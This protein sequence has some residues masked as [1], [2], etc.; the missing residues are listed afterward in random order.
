MRRYLAVL[1]GFMTLLA[2]GCRR[3]AGVPGDESVPPPVGD[4]RV[5]VRYADLNH[6]GISEKIRIDPS[7]TENVTDQTVGVFGADDQREP[8]LLWSET[9][10]TSPDGRGGIYL[11]VLEDQAYLMTLKPQE[12]RDVP[13]L[14][15][16]V[17]YL[18]GTGEK[19]TVDTVSY[20][21]GAEAPDAEGYTVYA[22][23]VNRYLS[24]SLVLVDTRTGRVNTERV[25]LL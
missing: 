13:S 19:I 11:V 17:F 12:N 25:V 6:D 21:D 1:C 22:D 9:V 10:T 3:S 4:E 18:A 14:A 16:E 24:K 15:C 23:K 2:A 5:I 20:Q 7:K 8:V